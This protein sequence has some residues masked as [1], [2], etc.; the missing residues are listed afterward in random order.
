MGADSID[1]TGLLP[2]QEVP[3]TLKYQAAL[4]L[5]HFDRSEEQTR[6]LHGLIDSLRRA[7]CGPAYGNGHRPQARRQKSPRAAIIEDVQRADLNAIEE[8]SAEE[9]GFWGRAAVR[10]GPPLAPL[11]FSIVASAAEVYMSP[12]IRGSV[13]DSAGQ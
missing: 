5:R 3:R 9:L 1:E 4:L 12:S 11:R 13:S 7:M 6:V 8:A 10:S 2:D